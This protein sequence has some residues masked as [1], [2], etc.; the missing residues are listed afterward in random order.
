MLQVPLS[1]EIEIIS[2]SHFCS[3]GSKDLLILRPQMDLEHIGDNLDARI[4]KSRQVVKREIDH[5]GPEL[6]L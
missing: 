6:P 2:F 1:P 5:R 4:L 3:A